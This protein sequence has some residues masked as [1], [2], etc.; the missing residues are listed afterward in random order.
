MNNY[1]EFEKPLAEVEGKAEEND[2]SVGFRLLAP[3]LQN[4]SRKV[5]VQRNRD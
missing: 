4:S 2:R 5:L 1:L 3:I